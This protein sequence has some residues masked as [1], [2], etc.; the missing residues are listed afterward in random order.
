VNERTTAA[1]LQ[2]ILKAD[3]FSVATVI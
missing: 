2:R 1:N 3:Y